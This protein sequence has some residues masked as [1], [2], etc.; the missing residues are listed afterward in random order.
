MTEPEP[1]GVGE[2]C[3]KSGRHGVGVGPGVGRWPMC[4]PGAFL[5]GSRRVPVFLCQL[6]ALWWETEEGLGV[7]A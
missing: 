2:D 7:G 3:W 5:T 1:R 6:L 4:E